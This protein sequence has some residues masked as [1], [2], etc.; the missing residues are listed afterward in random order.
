MDRVKERIIPVL[1]YSENLKVWNVRIVT[2]E[3]N[4]LKAA[5]GI[6]INT[7]TVKVGR[8]YVQ[9]DMSIDNLD[10]NRIIYIKDKV[11]WL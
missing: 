1:G 2:L 8:Y 4:V 6:V 9:I 10:P 11:I 7:T 3:V 5:I